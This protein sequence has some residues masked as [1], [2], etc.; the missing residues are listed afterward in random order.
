MYESLQSEAHGLDLDVQERVML[1]RIKGLYGDNVI[2][3][4]KNIMTS[5]EKACV[6]A[7]EIGHH[8]FTV[9]DILDQSK[10]NNV[11]QENIARRWAFAK[12]VPLEGLIYSFKQ[13]CKSRYDIAE[14]LNITEDFLENSLQY[15]KEK[16]GLQVRVDDRHIIFFD[17]LAIH[18]E[19]R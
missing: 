12:L 6:L 18:E 8:L 4:N 7:E 17:P 10:I 11:K 9:G 3:I 5:R 14:T 15:Y 16:H 13:G 2:W 19:I 1:E